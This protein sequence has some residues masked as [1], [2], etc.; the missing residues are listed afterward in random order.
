M[1]NRDTVGKKQSHSCGSEVVRWLQYWLKTWKVLQCLKIR[2][3]WNNTRPPPSTRLTPLTEERQDLTESVVVLLYVWGSVFVITKAKRGQIAAVQWVPGV[4]EAQG[5]GQRRSSARHPRQ[6]FHRAR[7]WRGRGG[8]SLPRTQCICGWN[9]WVACT[10][11]PAMSLLGILGSADQEWQERQESPRDHSIKHS[12]LLSPWNAPRDVRASWS[13]GCARCSV[14]CCGAGMELERG[15]E[16][17]RGLS[18]EA[19]EGW[20]G[21]YQCKFNVAFYSQVLLRDSLLKER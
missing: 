17:V 7:P 3:T 19:C 6:N 11:D 12:R 9:Q 18:W 21:E 1:W 16:G 13:I 8:A 20:S 4:G 5:L 14:G 2:R 15:L 10:V